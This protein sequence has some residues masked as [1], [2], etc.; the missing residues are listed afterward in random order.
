MNNENSTQPAAPEAPGTAEAPLAVP[1]IHLQ[2]TGE[3]M[4][5]GG[6]VGGLHLGPEGDRLPGSDPLHGVAVPETPI[7]TPTE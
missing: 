1:P 6:Y 4:F 7:T 5:Q 3:S 2:P